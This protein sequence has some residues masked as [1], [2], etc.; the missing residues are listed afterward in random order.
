MSIEQQARNSKSESFKKLNPHLFTPN[1]PMVTAAA[2]VRQSS[3]PLLNQLETEF[4]GHLRGF[5]WKIILCQS[6]KLRL[7]NGVWY[8]PDFITSGDGDDYPLVVWEVK[9]EHVWEDSIVKLK[10]AAGQYPFAEWRLAHKCRG[11]WEYQLVT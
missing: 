8:T 9:G 7:G 3:K 10:V 5:G 11:M 1:A 6:V 4:L 2:M